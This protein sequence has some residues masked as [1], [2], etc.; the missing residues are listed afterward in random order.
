MP[1]AWFWA[2]SPDSLRELHAAS[3][4]TLGQL[5]RERMRFNP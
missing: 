1:I 4:E 2:F 3:V 5:F